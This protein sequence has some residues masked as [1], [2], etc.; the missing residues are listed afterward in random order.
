MKWNEH[1]SHIVEEVAAV[2]GE[3]FDLINLPICKALIHISGQRHQ[4][5]FCSGHISNVF[6]KLC[7]I[8][9]ILAA[10]VNLSPRGD[11]LLRFLLHTNH[12]RRLVLDLFLRGVL[13]HVLSDLH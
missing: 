10:L 4:V 8:L 13:T 6:C 7:H 2:Q 11:K 9:S 3:R 12:Q 1:A 5:V